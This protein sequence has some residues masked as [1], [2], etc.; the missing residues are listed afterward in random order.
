MRRTHGRCVS[1]R[2]AR[3]MR[4]GMEEAVR[5][6]DGCE[7]FSLPDGVAEA[8]IADG[9][10]HEKFIEALLV[11]GLDRWRAHNPRARRRTA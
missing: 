10:P 1:E 6:L 8:A 3:I 11:L 2:A 5:R 7:R 4:E 9:R